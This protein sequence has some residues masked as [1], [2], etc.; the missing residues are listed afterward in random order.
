MT[1]SSSPPTGDVTVAQAIAS[2]V[3]RVPG[4][5]AMSAGRS[6]EAATYGAH[7]KVQGVI[8]RH[9]ADG[10]D[11]EVHICALYSRSLDLS[12]L[13]TQVRQAVRPSVECAYAG[14]ITR[15]DVVIDDLRVE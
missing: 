5:A 13:G 1:R 9:T 7:E 10:V 4:V 2:A 8:I 15:T 6:A 14:Q 11:I 3:T 12:E